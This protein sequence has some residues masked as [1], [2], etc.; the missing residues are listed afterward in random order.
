VGS[1]VLGALV[2]T[3]VEANGALV[4]TLV[5]AIGERVGTLVDCAVMGAARGV[6]VACDADEA[7]TGALTGAATGLPALQ[8]PA[9]L[10][11]TT[12]RASSVELQKH[13]TWQFATFSVFP[14]LKVD[15]NS[16]N[17]ET[18]LLLHLHRGAT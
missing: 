11:V 8:G 7:T 14:A 9:A 6:P 16:V 13:V 2:A 4:V 10:I 12:A 17:A 18:C 15:L 1:L 5:A 3:L